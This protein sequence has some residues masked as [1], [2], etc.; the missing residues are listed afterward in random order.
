[1]TQLKAQNKFSP[2]RL[3]ALLGAS[4][5][6]MGMAALGAMAAKAQNAPF[7]NAQP[8]QTSFTDRAN[9]ANDLA[10]LSEALNAMETFSGRF[11]QYNWDGTLDQGEIFLSRPGKIRFEYAAPSPL[12]LI[13]DGTWMV[14]H[15]KE[16][17]TT[18]RIPL[19]QTPLSFF[20]SEDVDL[21]NDVDVV[22]LVKTL[23]EVR[24]SARDGSGEVDG[25]LTMVF[26][27][28]DLQLKEWVVQDSLG[29]ET[30]VALSDLQINQRISARKFIF[31]EDSRRQR[32]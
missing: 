19:N 26:S 24:V 30:R 1:M 15:D 2:R 6:V 17:E 10:V 7:S 23:N 16:L 9:V 14:Q 11:T 28:P 29:T 3:R 25:I 5:A 27:S 32:R 18:D 13:S 22:G 20:L 12:L 4:I 21:A 31:R 8:A